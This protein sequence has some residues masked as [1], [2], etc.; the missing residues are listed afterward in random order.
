MEKLYAEFLLWKHGFHA[1]TQYEALLHALFLA[2]ASNDFLLELEECTTD[3]VKTG[4]AFMRGCGPALSQWDVS[5]FGAHLFSGLK[6]VYHT[7]GMGLEEF[8]KRCYQLWGDLPSLISKAEPF[9]TLSYA[10]DP[11]SWGD[12]A[13]TRSLY[14]KAFAFYDGCP[15]PFGGLH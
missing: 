10:D 13:Q 5:I 3:A 15:L 7:N 2:D 11:L 8:G 6:S 12:T 9:W 4:Q 14:E 1:K